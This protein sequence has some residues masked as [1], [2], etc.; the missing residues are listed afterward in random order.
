[1]GKEIKESLDRKW[2]IIRSR[3]G[4]EKWITK[5]GRHNR[6]IRREVKINGRK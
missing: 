2:R 6:G 1:M 5:D 3:I 4:N